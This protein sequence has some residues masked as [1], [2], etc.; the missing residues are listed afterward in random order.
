M[1]NSL[2]LKTDAVI[3]IHFWIFYDN[4]SLCSAQF[5]L[6]FFSSVCFVSFFGSFGSLRQSESQ[7][8]FIRHFLTKFNKMLYLTIFINF[9]IFNGSMFFGVL[10]HRSQMFLIFHVIYFFSFNVDNKFRSLNQ[11]ETAAVNTSL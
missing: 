6:T 8:L 7:I 10:F 5:F 2:L 1:F 9:I 4:F 3:N 11:P